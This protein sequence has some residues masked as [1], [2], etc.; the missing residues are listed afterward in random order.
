MINLDPTTF[1]DAPRRAPDP[2][3]RHWASTGSV[4]A[5]PSVTYPALT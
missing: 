5:R 3:F 1:A 4:T 2:S